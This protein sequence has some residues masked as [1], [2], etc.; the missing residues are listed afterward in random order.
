LIRE[1]GS[2]NGKVGI[3]SRQLKE[4]SDELAALMKRQSDARLAEV[5]SRMRMAFLTK[6]YPTV[7]AGCQAD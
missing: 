7:V 3:N 1:N 2:W 6:K 5:E 4:L